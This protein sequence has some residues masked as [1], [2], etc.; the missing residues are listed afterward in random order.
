MMKL[1]RLS[2][3]MSALT[4]GAIAIAGAIAPHA[5]ARSYGLSLNG[6]DGLAEF[7][8]IFMGFW[9]ALAIAMITAARRPDDTLLGDVCGVMLLFQSLARMVSFV[10]DGRPGPTFVGACF[11]EL[12]CALLILAP[13]IKSF[14]KPA[15]P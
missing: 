8:A 7:R 6:V 14:A 3:L 15:M 1:R 13:R 4:F 11:A 10:L 12:F 9:A 2:L 5:V